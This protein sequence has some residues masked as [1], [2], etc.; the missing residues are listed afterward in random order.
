MI[1]TFTLSPPLRKAF[2]V[3]LFR[4]EVVVPNFG[5]ELDLPHV[6]DYLVFAGGFAGL[7]F[8]VLEL[9]VVHHADDR[10]VRVRRDFDEVEVRP[11]PVVHRFPDVLDS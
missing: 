7:F 10:R 4:L 6:D 5:P 8:L 1:V 3:T 11:L 9:A 2:D